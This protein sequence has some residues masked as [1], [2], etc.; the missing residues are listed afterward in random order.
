[1]LV[2]VPDGEVL[3]VKKEQTAKHPPA[4]FKP[5]VPLQS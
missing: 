3:V 2:S 4:E 5:H 1:V